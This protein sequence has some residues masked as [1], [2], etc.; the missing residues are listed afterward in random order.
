MTLYTARLIGQHIESFIFTFC[1]AH[2]Y[3][4]T[5]TLFSTEQRAGA[6]RETPN[7]ERIVMTRRIPT[8]QTHVYRMLPQPIVRN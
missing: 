3:T 5:Q 8:F 6:F 2:T 4:H 7:I 1:P